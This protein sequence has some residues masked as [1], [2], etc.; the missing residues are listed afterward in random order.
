[1]DDE[2]YKS[3]DCPSEDDSVVYQIRFRRDCSDLKYCVE[4]NCAKLTHKYL[5]IPKVSYFSNG[6]DYQ[7]SDQTGS[8]INTCV[9][10]YYVSGIE[11]TSG[12]LVCLKWIRIEKNN[13]I[14][15]LDAVSA[16]SF[17]VETK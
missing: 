17:K 9:R 13:K 6:A 3:G 1:M 14:E 12:R 15:T 11:Y 8:Y 10:D 16:T 5:T 4:F 7:K 2:W